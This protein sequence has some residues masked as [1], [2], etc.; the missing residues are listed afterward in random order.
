MP[1]LKLHSN[2][3]LL[4]Y[5]NTVIGMQLALM[6]GLLHLVQRGGAWAGCSPAQSLLTIPNVT[7]HPSMASV[8]THI[9]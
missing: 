6:G 5:I 4:S 8:P 3:D 9:I 7:A 1:T 2:V